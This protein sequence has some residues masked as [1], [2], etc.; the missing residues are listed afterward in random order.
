MEVRNKKDTGRD[1]VESLQSSLTG[2]V[3]Q[4]ENYETG[5]YCQ[6]LFTIPLLEGS[7]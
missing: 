5:L 4:E 2:G 7:S 1:K 3:F 6:R